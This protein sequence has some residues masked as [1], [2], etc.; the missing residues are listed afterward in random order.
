VLSLARQAE[1][2][3]S[4]YTDPEIVTRIRKRHHAGL[5]VRS[6]DPTRVETLLSDYT[7]RFTRDFLAT[8]PAPERPGE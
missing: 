5:I 2:D 3:T 4:G 1:P 7:E 8:M 6:G